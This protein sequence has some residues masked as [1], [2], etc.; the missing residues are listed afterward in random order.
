[1]PVIPAKTGSSFSVST[2]TAFYKLA[3]GLRRDD[4]PRKSGFGASFYFFSSVSGGN[5]VRSAFNA[6][7][8]KIVLCFWSVMAS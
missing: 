6:A 7:T 8:G 2:K 1:M 4:E 5:S 3:P